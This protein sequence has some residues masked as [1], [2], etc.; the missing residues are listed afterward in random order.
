MML[1][2]SNSL[3]RPM[4]FHIYYLC[5]HYQLARYHM[6][7]FGASTTLSQFDKT[8]ETSTIKG[9]PYFMAPEVLSSS[10]YGRKGDVWAVGCTMIQASR[11]FSTV[12]FLFYLYLL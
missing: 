2:Q 1:A 9:T 6:T 5:T 8:Q 10:K 7:D 11:I 12:I 4:V 3:V